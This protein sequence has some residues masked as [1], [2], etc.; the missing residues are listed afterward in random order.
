MPA[1]TGKWLVPCLTASPFRGAPAAISQI[2]K[3][4]IAFTETGAS[5]CKSIRVRSPASVPMRTT[6]GLNAAAVGAVAKSIQEFGWRQPIVIDEDGVIVVGDA[7][8]G[9][10]ETGTG[11]RPRSCRHVKTLK[12]VIEPSNIK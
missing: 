2:A 3:P 6:R 12:N 9:R 7:P 10:V 11:D 8:Q 5:T 4:F 1:T